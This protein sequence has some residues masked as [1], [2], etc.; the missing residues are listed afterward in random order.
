M[1]RTMHF[2]LALRAQSCIERHCSCLHK[3][4]NF[5][6]AAVWRKERGLGCAARLKYSFSQRVEQALYMHS[7]LDLDPA[8]TSLSVVAACYGRLSL[9]LEVKVQVLATCRRKASLR[10]LGRRSESRSWQAL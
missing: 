4:R 2:G 1:I 6:S 9:S 5:P 7:W 10:S 3:M 8:A